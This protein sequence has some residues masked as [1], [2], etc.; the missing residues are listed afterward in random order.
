VIR[1]MV[2]DGAIV[3]AAGGGGIPVYI[4]ED[5]GTY[6]GL[7]V[8]VDK[9]RASA[10]LG[11]AIGAETLII[12]TE[13]DRVAVDF[14]KPTQRFLD[15]LTVA[16]ARQYYDDGHFPPG[17]MGPKIEAAIQFLE[18]GGHMVIIASIGEAAAV[19]DGKAGTRIVPA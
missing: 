3:I 5:D 2:E 15:R 13:V 16:E 11:C 18:G 17:S 9:D 7:D 12:L 8:V 6:E 14:G 1:A 4:E 19:L 10:V